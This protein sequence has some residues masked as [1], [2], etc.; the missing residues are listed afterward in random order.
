M[1]FGVV[2]VDKNYAI[3]R[4][5]QALHTA[6]HPGQVLSEETTLA[7]VRAPTAPRFGGRL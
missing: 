6:I 4:E 7:S 3:Y 2:K 1:G 5:K